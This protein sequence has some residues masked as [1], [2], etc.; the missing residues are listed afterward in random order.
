MT[1]RGVVRVDCIPQTSCEESAVGENDLIG[2]VRNQ[3]VGRVDISG[4]S[5]KNEM[6]KNVRGHGQSLRV[7]D[8]KRVTT[9]AREE[10]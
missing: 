10:R 2:S 1:P 9:V 5:R 3:E 7:C 4:D 8:E 6:E